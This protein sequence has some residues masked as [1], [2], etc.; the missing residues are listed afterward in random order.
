[1]VRG[2]ARLNRK[3]PRRGGYHRGF[4]TADR[5]SIR[6]RL[7]IR[8]ANVRYPPPAP[9]AT[10]DLLSYAINN[11]LQGMK[12]AFRHNKRSAGHFGTNSL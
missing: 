1:M 8:C 10:D 5:R 4:L 6:N 3:R 7:F 2:T 11:L 12:L 9:P